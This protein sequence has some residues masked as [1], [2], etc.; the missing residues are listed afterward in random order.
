M[1]HDASDAQY[2]EIWIEGPHGQQLCALINGELGW[3]MYLREPGDAGM[4]SRN[5]DYAGP[6]A[7]TIDY[8]LENG[9]RDEYPASW[10]LPVATLQRAIDAFRADGLPPAFVLWHRDD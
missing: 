4:S 1:S 9:Q 5:P 7:A 3:L 10:A 2:R 6:E 8:L